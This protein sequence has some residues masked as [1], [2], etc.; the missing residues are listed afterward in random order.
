M[1]HFTQFVVRLIFAVTVELFVL[2]DSENLVF[3]NEKIGSSLNLL[4]L[5]EIFRNF[6]TAN[7]SYVVIVLML[8]NLS[9]R[10]L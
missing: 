2:L 10:E 5:S 3:E 6:P 1:Q 4:Y 8:K 9:E 7:S